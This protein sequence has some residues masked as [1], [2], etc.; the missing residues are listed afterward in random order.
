MN[1]PLW[2]TNFKYHPQSVGENAISLAKIHEQVAQ[3]TGLSLAVAVNPLDALSVAAAVEI[4][5]LA[6]HFDPLKY[7]SFTGKIVAEHLKKQGIVGSLLNHAENSLSPSAQIAC[8]EWGVEHDFMVINCI[9]VPTEISAENPLPAAWALEP[10]ELIGSSSTSIAR[11]NPE[12]IQQAVEL[13]TGVPILVGAGI[14]TPEDVQVAKKAGAAGYLVATAITK[15]SDPYQKLH[16]LL[17]PW[18]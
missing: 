10:P 15:D 16:Q 3:E 6:Q 18:R 7:G 5:V 11:E 17:E 14:S 2:I 1:P 9:S 8:R 13:T 12:S 4:P